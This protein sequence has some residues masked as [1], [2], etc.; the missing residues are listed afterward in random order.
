MFPCLVDKGLLRF[1]QLLFAFPYDAVIRVYDERGNVI[2]TQE[3][4]GA[5]K[6]LGAASF[7]ACSRR[8]PAKTNRVIPLLSGKSPCNYG[9]IP[10]ISRY[11]DS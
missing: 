8:L 7:P 1:R 10:S 9:I 3:H 11:A 5:F 6:E 4:V 2:E